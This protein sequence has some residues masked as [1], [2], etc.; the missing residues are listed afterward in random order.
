[1]CKCAAEHYKPVLCNFKL[2]T[3]GIIVIQATRRHVKTGSRINLSHVEQPRRL[4]IQHLVCSQC[5]LFMFEAR[6][7]QVLEFVEP[8]VVLHMQGSILSHHVL[9]HSLRG[10]RVVLPELQ[11]DER[12]SIRLHSI[13]DHFKERKRKL[14]RNIEF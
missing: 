8:D 13:H 5:I 1:M 14:Y 11:D 10:Q 9:H 6:V 7:H 12:A 2:S 3:T 4:S